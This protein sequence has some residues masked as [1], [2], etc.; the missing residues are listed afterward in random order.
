MA[1]TVAEVMNRELMSLRAEHPVDYALTAIVAMGV[2]AAP[3][4][5]GRGA[6]C[7]IVSWRDLVG[8]RSE[9]VRDCMSRAVE[10]VHPEDRIE[11]AAMTLTTDGYH[12]APIVDRQGAL[13]RFVSTLDLL[14]TFVGQPTGHP[15]TC[16]HW[17][18]TTQTT[19]TDEKVLSDAHI[20][21]A[22]R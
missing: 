10:T 18:A 17:D 13:I 19:W 4:V 8:S 9:V 14:R 3:V 6:L 15:D 16:P 21:A 1:L 12:H 2:S 22:Q 11:H 7:G 5:D 20:G